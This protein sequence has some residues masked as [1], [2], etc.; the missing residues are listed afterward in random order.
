MSMAFLSMQI[1]GPPSTKL[2][3]TILYKQL[4]VTLQ[5]HLSI[6]YQHVLV[7]KYKNDGW[8]HL[9]LRV[10]LVLLRLRSHSKLQ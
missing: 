4:T 6:F 8:I 9:K 10:Y 7:T 1:I 3:I 2:L 5:K